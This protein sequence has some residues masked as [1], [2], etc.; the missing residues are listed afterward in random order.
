MK[1]KS[2]SRVPERKQKNKIRLQRMELE[3]RA[4]LT[5]LWL[6]LNFLTKLA[7]LILMAAERRELWHAIH[8]LL[9]L[10]R[11]AFY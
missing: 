8:T 6:V 4:H 7:I 5:A 1:P 9:E 11:I 2:Y 10:L 3:H